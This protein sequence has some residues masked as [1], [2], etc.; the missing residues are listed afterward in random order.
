LLFR[1]INNIDISLIDNEASSHPDKHI[2]LELLEYLIEEMKL[3]CHLAAF[4]ICQNHVRIVTIGTDIDNLIRGDSHQFGAGR[5]SEPFHAL[6]G[7]I[8]QIYKFLLKVPYK[9]HHF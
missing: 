8:L 5:Y 3:E 4:A 2:V 7:L 1:Q 6:T 9:M